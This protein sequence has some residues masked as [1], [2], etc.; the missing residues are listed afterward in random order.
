MTFAPGTFRFKPYRDCNG[1]L[2]W[3]VQRRILGVWIHVDD[4][5]WTSPRALRSLG[6][7]GC[8][9]LISRAVW[10]CGRRMVGSIR[11]KRRAKDSKIPP[12]VRWP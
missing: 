2:L 4:P 6:A 1:D 9:Y 11:A 12:D 10:H 5:A 3:L 8:K 7:D